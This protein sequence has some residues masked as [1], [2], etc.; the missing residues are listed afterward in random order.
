MIC[1][2]RTAMRPGVGG[3]CVEGGG[4]FILVCVCLC[5]VLVEFRLSLF[6]RWRQP[7]SAG[8]SS[9]ERLIFVAPKRL[10][11]LLLLFSGEMSHFQLSA[12]GL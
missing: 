8:F 11:S 10:M 6:S 2:G 3:G 12:A 1:V 5:S 7:L 4:G 9:P